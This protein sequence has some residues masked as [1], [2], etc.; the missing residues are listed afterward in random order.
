MRHPAPIEITEAHVRPV[1]DAAWVRVGDATAA[2][3]GFAASL[4]L[5]EPP[6]R[7]D[8][9]VRIDD[10]GRAHVRTATVTALNGAVTTTML[11]TIPLDT[12]LRESISR[13][14]VRVTIAEPPS[15]A[16][17][18]GRPV[19][20]KRVERAAQVY[21]Q[22]LAAGSY[23]PGEVVAATLGYSRATAARDIRTARQRGILAPLDRAPQS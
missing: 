9:T 6:A 23:A 1:D 16:E 12:L 10:S 17:K 2:P 13:A 14:T 18:R 5:A 11:H 19:P 15:Q 7:V 4:T 3:S 22:A 21:R 20:D 8:M